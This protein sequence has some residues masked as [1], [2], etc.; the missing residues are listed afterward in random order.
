MRVER[1]VV[2]VTILLLINPVQKDVSV[3]IITKG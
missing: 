2:F 1:L 3:P